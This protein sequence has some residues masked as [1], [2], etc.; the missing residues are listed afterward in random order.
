MAVDIQTK[1]EDL[2]GKLGTAETQVTPITQ[3]VQENELLGTQGQLLSETTPIFLPISVNLW[4]ALSV[5]SHKR[6][7]ALEV[8][9]L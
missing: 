4:S 2:A 5:L 1:T 3:G 7:S 9:I 6:Y 8:N